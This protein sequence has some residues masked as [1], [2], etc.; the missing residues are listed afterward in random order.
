[1]YSYLKTMRTIPVP[2]NPRLEI[3]VIWYYQLLFA[4]S[5]QA[6]GRKK[7]SKIVNPKKG[8]HLSLSSRFNLTF[9]MDPKDLVS[10][11]L[12]E[13]LLT[14]NQATPPKGPFAFID[15]HP[16]T[17]RAVPQ[18]VIDAIQAKG[19]LV[20]FNDNKVPLHELCLTI[21][22]AQELHMVGS[23]PLCLAL[24]I[25]SEN[26]VKIYYAHDGEDLSYSYPSW[27]T[28]PLENIDRVNIKGN[29]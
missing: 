28:S 29:G 27:I 25:G 11:R 24:T 16:G 8:V 6:V 1:M 12:R 15:T 3:L 13:H 20:V 7:L 19:L 5:L 18:E 23:A 17:H 9:G 22:S 2:N 26:P 14:Q 4:A 21:M 10:T